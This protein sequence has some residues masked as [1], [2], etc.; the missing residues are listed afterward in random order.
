MQYAWSIRGTRKLGDKSYDSRERD[1]G[2]YFYSQQDCLNFMG[3]EN[4]ET[5]DR[6]T[7]SQKSAIKVYLDDNETCQVYCKMGDT[8]K[9]ITMTHSITMR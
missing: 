7:L 8:T 2:L 6:N 5:V 9:V 1:I 3:I 4:S